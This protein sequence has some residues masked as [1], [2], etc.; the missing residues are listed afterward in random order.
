MS[1]AHSAIPD[2]LIDAIRANATLLAALGKRVHYQTIPQS[3][4]Y[5]HVYIARDG[6]VTEDF[7]DGSDGPTEDSFVIEFVAEAYNGTLCSEL[8]D[9]IS[10]LEGQMPG[11]PW[12]FCT[13]VTDVDDNYVFKSADSDALFLHA[14]RVTVYHS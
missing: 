12:V 6:R 14:F 13:D 1:V 2:L 9:S 4:D 11:G 5:P 8:Y 7:L 10:Q 3:S